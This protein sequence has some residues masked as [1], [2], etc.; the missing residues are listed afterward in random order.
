MAGG[1]LDGS[2]PSRHGAVLHRGAGGDV[3]A[4]RACLPYQVLVR[5]PCPRHRSVRTP[6]AGRPGSDSA[7]GSAAATNGLQLANEEPREPRETE[8]RRRDRV[9]TDDGAPKRGSLAI[10]DHRAAGGNCVVHAADRAA[11]GEAAC[12]G[13][14]ADGDG[15]GMT[16]G[17]GLRCRGPRRRALHAGIQLR[18]VQRGRACILEGDVAKLA[19]LLRLMKRHAGGLSGYWGVPMHAGCDGAHMHCKCQAGLE[20]VWIS[21]LG[22]GRAD[23]CHVAYGR[24]RMGTQCQGCG[25]EEPQQQR[26]SGTYR[27][28]SARHGR[29]RQGA[30][31]IRKVP[32]RPRS[33]LI[34][35]GHVAVVRCHRRCTAVCGQ[36]HAQPGCAKVA[37]VVTRRCGRIWQQGCAPRCRPGRRRC[38]QRASGWGPS[39][40]RCRPRGGWWSRRVAPAGE[41]WPPAQPRP[42]RRPHRRPP[43]RQTGRTDQN[44]CRRLQ[45]HVHDGVRPRRK[46]RSGVCRVSRVHAQASEGTDCGG[47]KL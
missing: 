1:A 26:Q 5:R 46:R 28:G 11:L 8:R 43:P 47:G 41:Q 33:R 35:K 29:G 7:W 3:T 19:H 13:D 44:L 36:G 24:S 4:A 22:G 39:G 27:G 14:G 15:G 2:V 21:A 38:R 37:A 31:G 12:A 10:R 20:G 45:P 32:G 30:G 6:R 23:M 18:T 16:P 40:G 42:P 25:H 9:S 17:R 34:R